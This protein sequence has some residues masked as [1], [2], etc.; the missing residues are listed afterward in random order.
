MKKVVA[1]FLLTLAVVLLA[2][3]A[4]SAS[5]FPVSDRA[6]F[7]EP[8]PIIAA[9]ELPTE[10]PVVITAT[11]PPIAPQ[12]E[13]GP[14][15]AGRRSREEAIE[16]ALRHAGISSENATRITCEYDVDDGVKEYEVEFHA[17]KYEYSYDIHAET[18]KILS[19][20]KEIDD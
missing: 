20:E 9:A 10:P 11:E 6:L 1:I 2:G 19:R 17:G 5:E 18:G 13:P 7:T 4:A 16:I 15:P 14:A 3:C 8:L 12:P